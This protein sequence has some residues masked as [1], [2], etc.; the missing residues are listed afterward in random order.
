MRERHWREIMTEIGKEFDPFSD[1]FC[2]DDIFE[3][4][5]LNYGELVAR[6][7][8]EARK[9]AKIEVGLVDIDAIW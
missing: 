7:A 2:L 9:E 8:D 1:G 3:L 5:L 6:L 4:G